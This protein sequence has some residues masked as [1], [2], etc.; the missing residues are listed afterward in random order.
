[1]KRSQGQQYSNQKLDYWPSCLSNLSIEWPLKN[2]YTKKK[3]NSRKFFVRAVS[4]NPPRNLLQQQNVTWNGIEINVVLAA[5]FPTA[6]QRRT[7]LI[8]SFRAPE[9][10]VSVCGAYQ[11][12]FLP[13]NGV[14]YHHRAEALRLEFYHQNQLCKVLHWTLSLLSPNWGT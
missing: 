13:F 6:L 4:V 11:F 9:M 7:H 1:M 3:K 10:Y 5:W 8:P 14:I 12:L 2:N